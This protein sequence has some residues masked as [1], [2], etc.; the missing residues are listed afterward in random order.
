MGTIDLEL[1]DRS[2]RHFLNAWRMS[3]RRIHLTLSTLHRKSCCHLR[4][5]LCPRARRLS[6]SSVIFLWA[7][8]LYVEGVTALANGRASSGPRA[9]PRTLIT[10]SQRRKRRRRGAMQH[11]PRTRRWS[12]P[13]TQH[14]LLLLRATMPPLPLR[15]LPTGR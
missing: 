12:R 10:L 11:R 5:H 2:S 1:L 4:H 15:T 7:A 14:L 6:V 3:R 13:Q 9:L 8:G